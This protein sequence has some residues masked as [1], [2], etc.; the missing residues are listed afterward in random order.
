MPIPS[1]KFL[2]VPPES[3]RE[4]D[5]I[6][7]KS[8]PPHNFEPWGVQPKVKRTRQVGW[9]SS[10]FQLWEIGLKVKRAGQEGSFSF[11]FL[12]SGGSRFGAVACAPQSQLVERTS[13]PLCRTFNFELDTARFNALGGLDLILRP[14]WFSHIIRR[15][16]KKLKGRD[17]HDGVLPSFLF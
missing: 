3:M 14:I 15:P 2:G 8:R 9:V 16:T 5:W 12:T 17:R 6:K 4:S 10:K 1:F 13:L 7:T 11:K